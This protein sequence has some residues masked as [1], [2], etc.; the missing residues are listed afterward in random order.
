MWAFTVDWRAGRRIGALAICGALALIWTLGWFSPSLY[1][2]ESGDVLRESSVPQTLV[3]LTDVV[4]IATGYRHTCALT[5]TNGVLCWGHNHVGQVGDG[6]TNNRSLPVM[7]SGLESGVQAISAGWEHTCALT[8][9]GAVL[10][11]GNNWAGQVG[12]GTTENRST[13]VAVNGLGSDVQAIVAG[14][15]HTC[16]LTRSGAMLCWGWNVYGQVGDGTTVNRNTPTT[17]SDF[18]SGVQAITAGGQHTCGVTSNGGVRCWGRNINGQIG[19]N[20]TTDRLTPVGVSGLGSGVQA[21]VGGRF[22]TCALTSSGGVVCWGFNYYGQ[23]GDGT[24]NNQRNTPQAVNGLSSGVQSV[25]T[26]NGDHTCA[27]TNNGGV[28]CWGTNGSGQVGD[29]TANYLRSSPTAV[30]GLDSGIQAIAAG[31]FHSCA[32]L[33]SG[34]AVCWGSNGF[35]QLGNG[36]IGNQ[37]SPTGVDGMDSN[38]QSITAAEDHTCA[39]TSSGETRCWGFNQFGQ[40]GDGTTESRDT[41]MVVNGLNAG[42]QL[43][44]GGLFHTCALTNSGGV[45]CWGSNGFTQIG[46]GTTSDRSTPT[47]VSGLNSSAE[48][49]AAGLHHSC[50]LTSNSGMRCWGYN[51]YG[52]LGDG[53]SNFRTTPVAVSGLNSGVEAIAAGALHTCALTNSGGVLCWGYNNFGQLGDGTTTQRN[54]PTVVNGLSSGVQAISAGREH[55]CA[56]TNSG[57]VLCWGRN[58]SGQLGDGTIDNRLTPTAVSGL[59]SGVQ[60][61]SVGGYH[62]CALTSSGLVCWGQNFVNQLGDGTSTDRNTPVAVNGLGTGVVAISAGASHTCVLTS[63]GGALCWGN[64]LYGQLGNGTAWRLIPSEVLVEVTEIPMRVYLPS[65]AR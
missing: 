33:S 4:Q 22:H 36:I 24:I 19:D 30:S 56:L 1:A 29:G 6:T 14:G 50:A 31:G 27:L 5:T 34:G 10:C 21:I 48:A 32:I 25:A 45:L 57:E 60:A 63:S 51:G 53:T 40:L 35:G 43:V 23:V 3:P 41:P 8:S 9:S 11:W 18:G 28:L 2:A 39:L 42:I 15:Y 13:P 52:Q 12:D 65:L 47:A 26:A 37:S 54:T 58:H 16:A 55:T 46:D 17:V 20:T 64:N 38:V 62:T 7:V 61:I 49:I 59:G 44:D